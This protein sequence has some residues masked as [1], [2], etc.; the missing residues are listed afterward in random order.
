MSV[1]TLSPVY[2]CRL[3]QSLVPLLL[4]AHSFTSLS[5][6]FLHKINKRV[7]FSFFGLF[8]FNFSPSNQH[9]LLLVFGPIACS[10]SKEGK[11]L[12]LLVK[13][14]LLEGGGSCRLTTTMSNMGVRAST[15]RHRKESN[16]QIETPV[17]ELSSWLADDVCANCGAPARSNHL[18]CSEHC[19]D[20]DA[21]PKASTTSAPVLSS[22]TNS[23]NST[24][25][26]KKMQQAPSW[27]ETDSKFRYPCP[28]S[29]NILAKYNSVL[30]SPALVAL[31]RSLPNTS[32]SM[33]KTDKDSQSVSS[34]G[35][36][37][38]AH[39]SK[40]KRRSSSR[41][42][43][44]SASD[45]VSTEHGTPSS[46]SDAIQDDESDDMDALS[47]A[48]DFH[49]PPS[50]HPFSKSTPR[51]ARSATA[52]PSLGVTPDR[53]NRSP[54][55]KVT[56]TPHQNARQNRN[57]IEYARKPYNT[58]LPPPV[59]FTSPVLAVTTMQRSDRLDDSL[60][61]AR[62]RSSGNLRKSPIPAQATLKSKK[63]PSY[64]GERPPLSSAAFSG[65][66][67]VQ[68]TNDLDTLA[69][70]TKP[71]RGN[72]SPP[73]LPSASSSAGKTLRAM[74][75]LENVSPGLYTAICGRFGCSGMGSNAGS[76]E[77]DDQF[78]IN[79]GQSPQ[80]P[81]LNR[82]HKH[83]HSAAAVLSLSNSRNNSILAA[84]SKLIMTPANQVAE[85][86]EVDEE[87]KSQRDGE[88]VENKLKSPPRGRSKARGRRSASHRS[89]SPP[90]GVSRRGN[91]ED[92]SK[93]REDGSS[94]IISPSSSRSQPVPRSQRRTSSVARRDE[95]EEEKHRGR[96]PTERRSTPRKTHHSRQREETS[97]TVTPFSHS[98]KMAWPAYGH[99]LEA[100]QQESKAELAK[101]V[102]PT[103]SKGYDDVDLDEL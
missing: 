21:K 59:L 76:L 78:N 31:E 71:S 94:A 19:K 20:E 102:D 90:R 91:S 35:G 53:S 29:P 33:T 44:S 34:S 83:T 95:P 86:K 25:P 16:H 15:T 46:I 65:P 101:L 6:V 60:E 18:Y 12:C 10:F 23:A 41:S 49:L 70:S 62:R 68:S 43:F 26:S 87:C 1:L 67:V 103:N 50:I 81:S 92:I 13:R 56:P 97:S 63:S 3:K 79:D 30:T 69:I 47:N 27:T 64:R 45:V 54:V 57:T 77:I 37:S 85:T 74:S 51:E 96:S 8:K 48:S 61:I 36:S 88:Q 17:E 38:V 89:P 28:P 9:I 80:R 52:T 40:T 66:V 11:K 39:Q 82:G 84:A 2:G 24:N 7:F 93:Q 32:T 5:R 75:P 100:W 14:G 4:L 98:C 22:Y 58:N 72:H 55:N 42:T 73:C 99:D